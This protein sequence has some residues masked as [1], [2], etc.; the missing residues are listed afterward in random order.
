MPKVIT[1][2][3]ALVKNDDGAFLFLYEPKHHGENWDL[4]GGKIQYGEEPEVKQSDEVTNHY[5][6]AGFGV[7]IPTLLSLC[8]LKS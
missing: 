1:S 2:V 6:Y 7:G 3:K 8:I 5:T 4:P